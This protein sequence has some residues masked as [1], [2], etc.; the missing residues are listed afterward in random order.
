M[1]STT[2]RQRGKRTRKSRVGKG[3]TGHT[4]DCTVLSREVSETVL[5]LRFDLW[6]KGFAYTEK[7][8]KELLINIA[9]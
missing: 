2:R 7:K 4:L 8:I 3:T 6:L 1:P 5:G 9:I